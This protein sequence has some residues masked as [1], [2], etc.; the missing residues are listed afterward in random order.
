MRENRECGR[1]E[2]TPWLISKLLSYDSAEDQGVL[3]NSFCRSQRAEDQIM[4]M[5]QKVRED[6][7][8]RE[9]GRILHSCA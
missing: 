6:R 8:C 2:S 7:K 9:C 1:T 3:D 4:Q 5:E